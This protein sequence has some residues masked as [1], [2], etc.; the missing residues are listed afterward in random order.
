MSK[1]IISQ[2]KGAIHTFYIQ[3]LS[4]AHCFTCHLP[5][6]VGELHPACPIWQTRQA[7]KQ[8]TLPPPLQRGRVGEGVA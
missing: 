3:P 2:K 7:K 1:S 4:R 5:D 8:R 6:C